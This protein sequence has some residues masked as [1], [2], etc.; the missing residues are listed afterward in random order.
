[1]ESKKSLGGA[2]HD[3]YNEKGGFPGPTL[4]W[5]R[6]IGLGRSAGLDA[7]GGGVFEVV[8]LN[9]RGGRKS[10]MASEREDKVAASRATAERGHML[11][12]EAA[13]PRA[14]LH[15]SLF[16]HPLLFKFLTG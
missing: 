10:M 7:V 1:M 14:A 2:A 4:L 15:A 11:V 5:R 8:G 9:G 6:P 16:R 13:A 3:E 12:S